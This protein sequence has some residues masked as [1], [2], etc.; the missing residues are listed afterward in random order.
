M[1]LYKKVMLAL[2][3]RIDSG[4]FQIG[5]N[6]PTE[7]KL[8]EEYAVSRITVRKAIDELVKMAMVEKRQGAGT[9]VIG[10]S[11]T[12]SM[13]NLRSNREYLAESGGK[14]SY[15]V[16]QFSLITPPDH[17]AQALMIDRN[18][19]VFFIRRFMYIN[20]VLSIYEDS[21]MPVRLFPDL[22]LS[23]L[24]GSKYHYLEQI[25]G[26][27]IDGAIQDF[28]AILP[29]EHMA[30]CLAVSELTP[31][32]KLISI[33]KLSDGQLF[34]YT[35]IVNKPKTYSYKHYLKR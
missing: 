14:L 6:L 12:G 13:S 19:K 30:Q 15:E 9:T 17:V 25:L 21:Y 35:E 31:L 18:E 32:L 2:K 7:T 34:E 29:N 22:S 27:K 10:Q 11:M 20:E 26:L 5:D 16:D 1:M 24:T 4:E 28:E 23:H 3:Q 8:V 33:G